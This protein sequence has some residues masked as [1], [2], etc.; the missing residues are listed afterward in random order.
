MSVCA[1]AD[2][3][4]IYFS[5]NLSRLLIRK[6]VYM[7][8]RLLI[9]LSTKLFLCVICCQVLP[10]LIVA[11]HNTSPHNTTLF[12]RHR[13]WITIRQ[14]VTQILALAC[15]CDK[16][17]DLCRYIAYY[18]KGSAF[19]TLQD[20]LQLQSKTQK[21]GDVF[22]QFMV[23]R[24]MY[25]L[26]SVPYDHY[27]RNGNANSVHF[28]LSHSQLVC[29]C[30]ATIFFL[31]EHGVTEND[32]NI[33]EMEIG[34]ISHCCLILSALISLSVSPIT[35]QKQLTS[36]TN[37][38]ISGFTSKAGMKAVT[39]LLS[40]SHTG[41]HRNTNT[42]TDADNGSNKY[43]HGGSL[44]TP[45]HILLS[46]LGLS[47]DVGAFDGLLSL[48]SVCA[49]AAAQQPTPSSSPLKG[50]PLLRTGGLVVQQ[51]Q[52]GLNGEISP[53]GT[54]DAL[55]FVS[56]I[57]S[58][59]STTSNSQSLL[60]S[61]SFLSPTVYRDSNDYQISVSAILNFAN[62]EGL[63]FLLALIS[64]PQHL[65]L[66]AQW[67]KNGMNTKDQSLGREPIVDEI[68]ENVGEILKSVMTAISLP[69][70]LPT[71][72]ASPSRNIASPSRNIASNAQD[73]QKILEGVYRTQ[74]IKSLLQALRTYGTTGQITARVAATLVHVL[75]ELVLT[76]SKFMTQFV[77]YNGL[78]VIVGV[79]S[80]TE[81]DNDNSNTNVRKDG[82][83][84]R[85]R[86]KVEDKDAEEQMTV[87]M[88]Q[89]SSHLARHSEK[90]F[91][92]LQ[93]VFT[94]S[95]LIYLLSKVRTAR[96]DSILYY[97]ILYYTILYYTILYNA[98]L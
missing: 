13:H 63:G 59:T 64:L 71:S 40:Y 41:T 54:K 22:S 61:D 18:D 58:I 68:L 96:S 90:Y 1:A 84:I 60:P 66:C 72:I 10:S 65:D 28:C 6:S 19:L 87:C 86:E 62:Q 25:S 85:G 23:L 34:I 88:L 32:V 27:R 43:S 97:T 8:I 93:T 82:R 36:L 74:L 81:G 31:C 89:I 49:Y 9:L 79:G 80:N 76:S 75:S 55:H 44:N 51:L 15:S 42:D 39:R 48:L 24:I 45:R 2:F 5:V 26:I 11:H 57:L 92:V 37:M 4:F 20:T 98:I 47:G 73:S 53:K 70:L 95:R 91:D 29:C 46:D 69:P 52:S 33:T 77:E 3:V 38:V 30:Q 67:S 50:A 14:A 78:E 16:S 35:S 17:T 94:P 21:T 56:L 12:I 7:D 83:G